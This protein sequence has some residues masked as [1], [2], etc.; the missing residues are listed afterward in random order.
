[1]TLCYLEKEFTSESYVISVRRPKVFAGE[2]FR[3]DAKCTDSFVVL[4]GWELQSKRWFSLRLES[5]QVPFLFQ[6]GKGSQWASTS[7]ELLTTLA[8]LHCFGWLEFGKDRKTLGVLLSAG[9]DNS[10]N[11]ADEALSVKRST[12]RPIGPLWP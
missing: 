4:D 6:P 1:M 9:T 7:A 12:T 11:E 10:A 2:A 3:T 5:S 8:A